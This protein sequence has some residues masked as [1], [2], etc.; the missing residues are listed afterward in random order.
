MKQREMTLEQVREVGRCQALLPRESEYVGKPGYER[1][2]MPDGSYKWRYKFQQNDGQRIG[3]KRTREG[4]EV[5]ERLKPFIRADTERHLKLAA[6]EEQVA[7]RDQD[8][9]TR[10]VSA[11]LAD[12]AARRNGWSH[13]WRARG[14]PVKSGVDGMQ[15]RLIRDEWE[16]LGVYC[17]G[18]PIVGPKHVPRRGIQHD[19]DGAPWR[20]VAGRWRKVG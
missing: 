19:P 7:L 10:L 2:V 4:N 18:E 6:R 8:G 5:L 14:N 13:R 17:L 15:F 11:G 9:G 16:P 1:K 3:T 20:F 12:Q